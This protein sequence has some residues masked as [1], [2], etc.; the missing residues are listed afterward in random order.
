MRHAKN[1][2]VEVLWLLALHVVEAHA[3]LA[4]LELGAVQTVV[5][6]ASLFFWMEKEIVEKKE[7]N[8]GACFKKT[9]L[10]S[11]SL[12]AEQKMLKEERNEWNFT[13]E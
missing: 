4:H 1:S 3:V 2:L 5:V 10:R 13:R 7:G 11:T 9:C 12:L 6:A 8:L